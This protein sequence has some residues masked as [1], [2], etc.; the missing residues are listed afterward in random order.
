MKKKSRLSWNPNVH[1]RVHN[2]Q[3]NPFT[4]LEPLFRLLS[5]HWKSM[6]FWEEVEIYLRPAGS[7]P[8][9]L[10]VGLPSGAHDQIFVFCLT[11]A[12]FFLCGTPSL[13]RGRVCNLLVQL[14]LDLARAV[15][16]GSKS[17]RTHGHILLSHLRLP[18]PGGPGPRIYI[19][20]EQEV[21]LRPTVSRPV[22]LGVRHPSGTCD[23]F[24]FLLEIFFRLCGFVILQLPPWREDG[25]VIYCYW[26]PSPAQSRLGLSPA[27]LKTVFYCPNPWDSPQP[28][29]PG[30]RK[31]PG[32]GFPF[33]RLL[34]LA[35]L[36]W[37][38]S[39]P[40]PHG[41]PGHCITCPTYNISVRT[42]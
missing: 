5:V 30:P 34:R 22:C 36:R 40:P 16:P 27:V 21:N 20:Q 39:I 32:T 23:Q 19:L 7:R 18:Q 17:C 33:R 2:S 26:W 42:A 24:F 9:Y 28:G 8:V 11:I 15:T 35:G 38:Y 1:Y 13:T 31:P 41:T 6:N 4:P 10:G 3:F 12:V 37:R 29:G 14:L 25:S